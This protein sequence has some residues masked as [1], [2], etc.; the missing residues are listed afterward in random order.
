MNGGSSASSRIFLALGALVVALVALRFVAGGIAAFAAW[1]TASAASE[2]AG[3]GSPFSFAFRH[4]GSL[5]GGALLAGALLV[6]V[7]AGVL[8]R[9]PWARPAAILLFA[10][11]GAAA[12]GVAV[13]QLSALARG[14]AVPADAAEVGYGPMLA[15]WRIGGAVAALL[16]AL[17][18]A[19]SLRR[20]T[21]DEMRREF[22]GEPRR[23]L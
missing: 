2:A 1:K 14:S 17:F 4:A 5:L 16:L 12:A 19:A 3:A 6:G 15:F 8:R 13:F 20:F 7:A 18:C 10:A 21:S 22:S 9:R 11:T 23:P